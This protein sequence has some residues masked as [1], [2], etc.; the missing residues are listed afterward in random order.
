LRSKRKGSSSADEESVDGKDCKKA[1]SEHLDSEEEDVFEDTR[2]KSRQGELT[3]RQP[4]DSA[5]SSTSSLSSDRLSPIQLSAGDSSSRGFSPNLD[6]P[7]MRRLEVEAKRGFLP[8]PLT[9]P[10]TTSHFPLIPPSHPGLYSPSSYTT[11][12]YYQQMLAA[13]RYQQIINSSSLSH[14]YPRSPVLPP[15]P[16]SL[17]PS[18]IQPSS[19]TSSIEMKHKPGFRIVEPDSASSVDSL[20]SSKSLHE[21]MGLNFDFFRQ[22]AFPF[23]PPPIPYGFSPEKM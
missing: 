3:V 17:S 23:P 13:S 5:L 7:M 9:P 19:T 12:L 18:L 16:Q 11:S 2:A 20:P 14:F 6:N 4:A 8:S 10:S 15:F 1:R 22:S 21:T